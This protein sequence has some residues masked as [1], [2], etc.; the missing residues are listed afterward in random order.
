MSTHKIRW[1]AC[2]FDHADR[3]GE[4]IGA[5]D[6]SISY[7][8]IRRKYELYFNGARRGDFPDIKQAR[9]FAEANLDAWVETWRAE[10]QR[11]R[12]AARRD[13]EQARQAEAHRAELVA[14]LA[15]L[16]VEVRPRM[17]SLTLSEEAAR[18][19]I[20]RLSQPGA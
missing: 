20:Q 16:G 1:K 12:E 18:S 5:P 13:L 15:A 9:A 10:K 19:L 11:V 6:L 8:A 2:G 14:R 4:A 3:K 7:N 17:N